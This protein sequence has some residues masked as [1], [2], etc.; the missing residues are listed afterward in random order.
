M[1]IKGIFYFGITSLSKL[2]PR[3]TGNLLYLRN[4]E[5]ITYI[6]NK[7]INS[8]TIRKYYKIYEIFAVVTTLLFSYKHAS[9][10]NFYPK[11]HLNK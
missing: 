7:K 5:K 1:R 2:N 9:W 8:L 11:N 3:L 6:N 4:V 10:N